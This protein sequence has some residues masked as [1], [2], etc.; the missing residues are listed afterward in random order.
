MSKKCTPLRREVQST[1]CSDPLLEVEASKK[2]TPLQPDS[3][4]QVKMHKAPQC[5]STFGSCAVKKVRAVVAPSTFP[6]QNVQST[7][8]LDHSWTSRCRFSW[9]AQ[10][11]MHLVKSEQHMR[12]L[13]QLQLNRCTTLPSTTLV[14][15]LHLQ[16][17]LQLRCATL[18][19]ANYV[20]LYTPLHY[21]TLHYTQLHYPTLTTTETTTTTT[22]TLH[23]TTLHSTPLHY[24]QVQ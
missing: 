10:G 5:R 6:S 1:P 15:K 19:Y 22:S 13:R 2:R 23:Y 17:H 18:H 7:T 24:T 20:T 16:L 3:H 11:V 12:V 21:T 9:R 8:C 4:F 14:L